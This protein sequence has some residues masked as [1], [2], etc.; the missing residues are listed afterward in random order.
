MDSMMLD[1]Q[2]PNDSTIRPRFLQ[3]N[4]SKGI[5]RGYEE[6]TFANWVKQAEKAAETPKSDPWAGLR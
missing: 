5:R 4:D 1:L 3:E 2:I 6:K